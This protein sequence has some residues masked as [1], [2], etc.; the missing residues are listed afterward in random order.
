MKIRTRLTLL[1]T[2]VMAMLL[3]AFA[4]VIY[5]AYSDNREEEFFKRIRQQAITRADLLLNAR[6]SPKT[7]QIIYDNTP[8]ALSREEVAIFDS[9]H[10]LLYHDAVESDL[11][12]ETPEMMQKIEQKKQIHFYEQGKQAIGFIYLHN[13]K[14]YLITAAAYDAY[15]FA[16]L[17]RLG[18]ILLITCLVSTIFIFLAAQFL[19]WQALK[20]VS[21]LVQEVEHISA[22]KLNLRVQE[23][24]RKDEIAELGIT[25]NR[26][27]D[28]LEQSFNAQKAFVSHISHELRTP[29]AA[30]VAELGLA[31]SRDR[32][33]AEYQQ[34]VQRTQDDAQK[35][36]RLSNDLLDFAKASYDETEIAFKTI[37]LDELLLDA[38]QKVLKQQPAYK[39]S[40][41][42]HNEPEQDEWISVNGN[43]YLLEV[44]F[45]NLIENGCKFSPDQ[46]VTVG[47]SYSQQFTILEFKD[48]G[49][50]ISSE[51]LPYIF[52]PF[53]RGKDH[54]TITGNGIGLSL[55]QKIISLHHGIVL[56]SSQPGS[57]TTF[58][59]KIPHL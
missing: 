39:A 31:S 55:V 14:P 8:N 35:L 25:F 17:H 22:T 56:V 41:E 10:T 44:A 4:L 13:Q 58:I 15:G 33:L 57:G 54:P 48:H 20:P 23:G 59:V 12:K 34:V 45:S 7:L 24:N 3:V 30:I 36:V 6:V 37:R 51:D 49:I 43:W 42:F 21:Q 53:Y 1:F 50:G 5:L 29:L 26:M 46:H 11:I 18:I 19:A 2:A 27:L 9:T 16:K 47:I 38:Q 52:Q 40:F 32:S 28:R